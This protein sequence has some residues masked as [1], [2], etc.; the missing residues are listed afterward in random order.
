VPFSELPFGRK[1]DVCGASWKRQSR[2]DDNFISAERSIHSP[3]GIRCAFLRHP[4][5]R[6][7][8]AEIQVI[9]LQMNQPDA[10]T[11]FEV[12]RSG[13]ELPF[14]QNVKIGTTCSTVVSPLVFTCWICA[15]GCQFHIREC[16]DFAIGKFHSILIEGPATF[17][18]RQYVHNCSDSASRLVLSE[19][20]PCSSRKTRHDLLLNCWFYQPFPVPSEC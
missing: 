11:H 3:C 13:K 20:N 4:A 2:R 18:S 12:V 14:R 1:T 15:G 17:R 9:H 6:L 19:E 16:F 8:L 7:R 5:F 10:I